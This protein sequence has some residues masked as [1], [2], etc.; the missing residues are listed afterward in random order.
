MAP[1]FV[2]KVDLSISIDDEHFD[3]RRILEDGRV[4]LECHQDGSLKFSSKEELLDLYSKGK[5]K[6]LMPSDEAKKQGS[7]Y[8]NRALSTFSEGIQKEAIRRK[9]YVEK[10]KAFGPFN[11][12]PDYLNPLIDIVAAE[13]GDAHPPSH[14]SVWRWTKAVSKSG[15]DYRV[16]IDR[17]DRKGSGK[18]KL[19]DVVKE[20]MWDCIDTIYMTQ[21]RYAIQAV[22]DELV[23]RIDDHNLKNI[24]QLTAPSYAT[25][26]RAI[27]SIDA[28]E[29]EKARY[30]KR[31]ADIRFRYAGK[32]PTVNNVMELVEVDHTLMDVFAVNPIT[33]EIYGRPTLTTMLCK[34][35]KVPVGMFLG[36][37]GPCAEA[38]LAC[39]KHAIMPKTYVKERFP[40][41]RN[42]WPCYGLITY[43]LADNGLEFHGEALERAALEIGTTV[44]YC[45]PREPYYKGSLERYQKTLNYDFSRLMPGH[46]FASWLEREDYDPLKHAIIPLDVL[47][48]LLHKWII[49]VYMQK[50][51]RGIGMSPIQ[52][53]NELAM[54][55]P[56]QLV[57]DPSRL[58][59]AICK[60]L[61]RSLSHAGVSLHSIRYN[62]HELKALRERLGATIDVEVC[63]LDEDISYVYV[64]DP[65]TKEHIVVPALNQENTRGITLYQHKRLRQIMVE[66]GQ[67]PDVALNVARARAEL[68]REVKALENS[69]KIRKKQRAAK[70][71][72]IGQ[73]KGVNYLT[74]D[75]PSLPTPIKEIPTAANDVDDVVADLGSMKFDRM[76]GKVA[77]R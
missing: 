22:H 30:G 55:H 34:A 15:G 74:Q 26:S 31:L 45:P 20:I 23:T 6:P 77:S 19:K 51:H 12:S 14:V 28:Y 50:R 62:N 29:V 65:E 66:K 52:K 75:E 42:S 18:S 36:F 71:K 4:Q 69:N 58:D 60:R 76:S 16:L 49:D 39:L 7:L 73:G 25:V 46:S 68:V 38:V 11:S 33:G 10:I 43:L 61:N 35:S 37:Q 41:I 72:G 64:V 53:W 9:N 67:D 44:G 70:I 40:D 2:I 21:D 32:S 56:P 54:K 3:V 17:H 13:L 47:D 27:G 63:F 59:I 1:T 57:S 8:V 24:G 48:R 5:L